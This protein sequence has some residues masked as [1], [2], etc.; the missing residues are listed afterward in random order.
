MALLG[1]LLVYGIFYTGTLIR[2]NIKQYDYIGK[3]DRMERVITVNGTGEVNGNNDIAMTTIGYSNT[4]KDVAKAQ[5]ANKKVMDQIMNALKGL[6]VAD[7][8]MQT[9]YSIYP[10]YNYTQDRGQQLIGYRVSNQVA[11]KIR[12]LT[13]IPEILGLAGQYGATEVA[14]LSF[15]IDEPEIL[16]SQARDKALAD[17]KLKA[18][19]LANA[20]NVRLGSVVSFNEYETGGD[21]YPMSAKSYGAGMG[22]GGGAPEAVAGGSK[23]VTMSVSVTYEIWPR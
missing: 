20:L 6:G 19:V 17:A 22:V 13:K 8:D 5:L 11:V 9:N 12:D 10:E 23:D 14:G 21:Y 16:K 1:I 3:A 7:K 2:N 4:D 18:A 15:T